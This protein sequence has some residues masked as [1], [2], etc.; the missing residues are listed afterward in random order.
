MRGPLPKLSIDWFVGVDARVP[1]LSHPPIHESFSRS[2]L[3]SWRS[4]LVWFQLSSY[5]PPSPESTRFLKGLR[6]RSYGQG[7]HSIL[8]GGRTGGLQNDAFFSPYHLSDRDCNS[9]KLLNRSSLKWKNTQMPGRGYRTSWSALPFPSPR[10]DSFCQ[11]RIHRY[12]HLL[13][14]SPFKF[15]KSSSRRVGKR[16]LRANDKV[17][18]TPLDLLYCKFIR[19]FFPGIRNFIV[20]VNVKVASDEV[21]M[22]K[23]KTYINKL[24]LA[25]VQVAFFPSFMAWPKTSP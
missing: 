8:H 2:A 10:Y 18:N 23:E 17:D 3:P 1:L 13:S 11:L 19:Y 14:T 21:S 25:L 7:R 15:S 22:R 5:S 4:V 24:N 9:N 16:F 12:K 20:G 6:C